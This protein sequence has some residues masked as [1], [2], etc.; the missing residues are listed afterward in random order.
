MLIASCC[1][2]DTG[3]QQDHSILEHHG[4]AVLMVACRDRDTRPQH[5]KFSQ[6]MV[7]LD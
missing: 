6:V 2:R 4:N 1:G 3:P 7:V 5:D